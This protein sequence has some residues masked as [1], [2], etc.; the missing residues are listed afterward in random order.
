MSFQRFAI[1]SI[2]VLKSGYSWRREGRS[3]SETGG[4]GGVPGGVYAHGCTR[5]SV[6]PWVYQGG[7]PAWVYQGG[8]TSVGVPG[9]C[10]WAVCTRRVYMGGVYQ[11]GL[12]QE[13]Y[14]EGLTRKCNREVKQGGYLPTMVYTRPYTHHGVY[15]P[16]TTL[17][18][19]PS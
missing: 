14:Q 12:N 4:G 9:G 5:R 8:Y 11:G 6:C 15:R 10:T 2:S 13:V 7:I 1:L 19:P 16:P 3:N 18:T 17:Y